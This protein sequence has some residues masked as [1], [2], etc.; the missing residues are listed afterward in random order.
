[1]YL[2]GRYFWNKRTEENLQRA[3]EYFQQAIEKDPAYAL[4]YSGLADAYFYLGYTFGHR[5]P[6]ESMPM[7]KAAAI[8]AL[9]IDDRLAEAHTSLAIVRLFYDWDWKGAEEGFRRANEL[10]PNYGTTH[11]IYAVLLAVLRRHDESIAEAQRALEVDPL[12]VPINNIA[13]MM[14]RAAGRLD[15][16]VEQFHKTLEMDPR[17][18]LSRACLGA[19]YELKGMT[20]LG[21]EEY[22]R[23]YELMGTNAQEVATLRT[24]YQDYGLAGFRA[25]ALALAEARWNGWHVDAYQIAALHA[26]LGHDEQ[27]L[28]WL[29]KAYEARSGALLWI[30]LGSPRACVGEPFAKL[31]SDPRFVAFLERVGLPA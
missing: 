26:S 1:M 27:A 5:P 2:R 21:V 7:A 6:R 30:N 28:E 12:S 17:M 4:A 16:A 8:K 20:D 10:N 23:A 18:A 14:Y 13:A 31:R 9:E 11:H 24:A 29:E 25:Q 22:L 19:V 3:V 15:E